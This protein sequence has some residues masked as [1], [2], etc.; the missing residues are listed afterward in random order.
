L[1]DVY[2]DK[3]NKFVIKSE[4]CVGFGLLIN[5]VYFF[6]ISKLLDYLINNFPETNLFINEYSSSLSGEFLRSEC[7]IA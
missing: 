4:D 6:R 1:G 7:L 5:A 2:K 3:N